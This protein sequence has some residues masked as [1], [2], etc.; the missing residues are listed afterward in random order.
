MDAERRMVEMQ[1]EHKEKM[2]AL[3]GDYQTAVRYVK[4]T[5]KMLKRMKVR[6]EVWPFGKAD[7]KDELN[8]QKGAN[9]SLQGEIDSLTGRSST[10][11]G[12]RTRDASG[13]ATPSASESELHRRMDKLQTQH[14]ALQ[15]EL[16][17]SR[18]VLSAREREVEVLR[19]RCE[20]AER[21]VE[22]LRDD[23][24][25]AQQRISTLL[26]MGEGGGFGI[27]SDEDR[28][29]SL[30]SSEEASMAFDKVYRHCLI[31]VNDD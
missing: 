16:A 19:M 24:A 7:K 26:D 4:G 12:S 8:K 3:E 13:R 17:A 6:L 1:S 18:D 5:E 31:V 9:T 14:N 11:P 22:T 2:A 21:E 30:E 29:A 27:G 15:A 25:Q 28:R 20:E 23:L 10:E